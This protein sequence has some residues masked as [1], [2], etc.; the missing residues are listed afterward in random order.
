MGAWIAFLILAYKVSQFETTEGY[1]P[2]KILGISSGAD[3]K[4]ISHAEYRGVVY[5]HFAPTL[6]CFP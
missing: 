6:V 2:Y 4:Y 1:D 5:P 3:S